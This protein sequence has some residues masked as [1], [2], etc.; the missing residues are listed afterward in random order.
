[1]TLKLH[2]PKD[3]AERMR[4]ALR[5]SP[6]TWY[7][8]AILDRVLIIGPGDDGRDIYFGDIAHELFVIDKRAFAIAVDHLLFFHSRQKRH[9][10]TF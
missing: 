1:M 9:E 3:D 5:S 10:T 7:F 8:D 6:E 2:E 4:A